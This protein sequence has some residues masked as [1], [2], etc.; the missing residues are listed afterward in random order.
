MHLRN[1]TERLERPSWIRKAGSLLVA[2]A[3]AASGLTVVSGVLD[4]T[5]AHAEQNDP[6]VPAGFDTTFYAYMQAGESL[7]V[8]FIKAFTN[9]TGDFTF[10]VTDPTGAVVWTCTLVQAQGV[11]STCAVPDLVGPAGVWTII[12]DQTTQTGGSSFDWDITVGDGANVAQ[13]GRVWTE[14]YGAYQT[15][16]VQTR[17]LSYTVLNDTG[18]RYAVNLYDY[19]GIGSRIIANSL[20][21]TNADG[22]PI[23]ESGAAGS[24]N[25]AQ[26][27]PP[28][29]VFFEEPSAQ[30]P[31]TAPSAA[32]TM[33][34]APP[35]LTPAELAVDDLAFA[36][37]SAN[38]GSG[39]FSYSIDDRFS[40][41]YNLQVDTNGNGSYDDA[42]DRTITLGADGTG[43]YTYDFDGLDGEGNVVADC[44]LMNARIFFEQLGEIHLLQVDVEGRNGGI[45]IIRLNGSPAAADTIYWN[46]TNLDATT[47]VRANTTPVLDG[48]GGVAS[49]GGVHGWANNGNSWGNN[50]TIDDWTYDPIALEAAEIQIGGRCLEMTKTSDAT[51]DSRVGDTVTYTVTATNT[52]VL[53]YTDETPA[54]FTD[55]LTGVLDDAEYNTDAETDVAGAITYAE[56][57]LSWTGALPAG[58]TVTMTYTTT[59]T[60]TGDGVVRNVA[61][62]DTP[63]T[64]TPVCDPPDEDGTD[65]TTGIACAENEFELPR[66]TITKT[67]SETELP[68]V[69]TEVTYTVTATNEGP[70]DFTADAPASITDDLTEVLDDAT[71]D[72]DA[73][74]TVDGTLDYDAP[75]LTWN[76]AL[77]AGESVTIEYTVTYTGEGDQLLTNTACV[78]AGDVLPGADPCAEV[79][80]PGAALTEWKSVV[81]SDSPLGEGDTL[82]Y[83]LH[84]DSTGTSAADVNAID[85]LVHVLDDA[86]VTVEPIGTGGV[87]AV[88]TGDSIAITGSVAPGTSATVTYTVT[89]RSDAER[90]DNIAANFLLAPDEEPPT[91]PVCVP[92]D[93][94][95]PDCTVNLI[96]E[97]I[98]S[99]AVTPES[100]TTVQPGQELT[101]TLTFENTGEGA[102][103]V[104]RVDDLTHI[105]DDATVTV[106][107][108]ASDDVL[109]VSDIADGRFSIT[110]ELAAGQTVTVTYTVTVNETDALGDTELG[111]FLLDPTDPTPEN[112][113]DCEPGSE[114]CTYNPVPRVEDSKSVTPE[115]GTIVEPGQEL[116]YTLTFANTGTVPADVDRVDDLTH[117]LDDAEVTVAPTASDA[118]LEVS[119]IAD[120]RFS[121]TGELAVGQ[122]VTVTYTVTVNA[123]DELGDAELGNFLLDPT[124]PT[125]ENPSDCEPGSEDCTYNPAPKL[126]DTKS[127]DPASGTPVVTGQEL[128]YTL[129]FR[130]EGA[131]AGGVSK[132]DDLT[133]VLDDADITAEPAASDVALTVTRD[134]ARITIVGTLAAGQEVTVTYTVTPRES[135]ERGDDILANFLLAPDQTPPTD[136]GDCTP[137]EG[138]FP[139]CTTNP[140]GDIAPAKSVNPTTGTTVE[141]GQELT[142]T[143]TFQNTGAGAATVDYT[144]FM[145]GVLDDAELVGTPQ[146]SAGLMTAGPT[147]GELRVT[148]TLEAGQTAT[149]TYTV[150]VLGYDQQGDHRLANFLTPAGQEP[151]TECVASNP[152]CTTNPIDP[153]APGDGLATTGGQVAVGVLITG[154]ALL[155]GGGILLMVRRRREDSVD[156]AP[157]S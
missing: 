134:G 117:I 91:D 152:L 67:A 69:G 121:I 150:R 78:P 139:D 21:L 64:P 31:A 111:N 34:I 115:S 61:Y 126:V 90:G 122:T 65:P 87:T 104:N 107:P 50:R 99:K 136:P 41:A 3:L 26:T 5:P 156:V 37:S 82:T 70:G 108:S 112:P 133:H 130:N 10:S 129:T 45:E 105:L 118:A 66:L 97:I 42:V 76:G 35:L 95:F 74:S 4:A 141:A 25:P 22:T 143:L 36:P 109:T 131:A 62:G 11:G 83:T 19:N 145:S 46:D 153:P 77:A 63:D 146:A 43:Q 119:D 6:G 72:D 27:S 7:D 2:G 88:R 123:N 155:I 148:G 157:F 149:V 52:G 54:T 138:E 128:T 114:D 89:L 49:T 38:S 17:D 55:D 1:R 132:V 13:T 75:E 127:V 81:A 154:L 102:G 86:D 33:I 15:D 53:D 44:T 106:A 135:G 113:S 73:T 47:G 100:G 20:G 110:G 71:F 98:D 79:S 48:T 18:Y 93:S 58:D 28:Y 147:N 68:A 84:F 144:D 124:D 12:Q 16:G 103:T 40:G 24:I 120:G 56:P 94:E 125:P 116:T 80:I 51:A 151:P 140:I 39:T 60:A 59:L 92:E 137:G 14:N 101:Y 142:Y 8:S 85:S 30:L 9:D 57:K 23:Y 96:P 32:G 29:R